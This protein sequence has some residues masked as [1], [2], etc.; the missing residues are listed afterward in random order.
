MCVQLGR[1]QNKEHTVSSSRCKSNQKKH[2]PAHNYSCKH[3]EKALFFF[4]RKNAATSLY[5]LPC[6]VWWKLQWALHA[7]QGSQNTTVVDCHY[8]DWVKLP[9]CHK[10]L[11]HGVC[12]KANVLLWPKRLEDH[13]LKLLQASV[14]HTCLRENVRQEIF[15]AAFS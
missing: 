13:Y 2:T 15:I 11:N 10:T 8:K 4:F 9:Y 14:T 6:G 1:I 7:I 5:M 12:N 3:C